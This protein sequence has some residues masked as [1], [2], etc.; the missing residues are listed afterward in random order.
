MGAS[1]EPAQSTHDDDRVACEHADR[2]G[3]CPVIGLPYTEQ[4]A[5][6]RG[7][8]VQSV[9]RYA[10]LELV[11]TDAVAPA[12]PRV[13]YRTRAKL[14][15]STGGR[16]GLFAKGGGHQVVDIPGC[17]VLASVLSRVAGT[18]RERIASDETCTGPLCP[19][20]PG[21]SGALRAVDLREVR[22]GETSR[23][24]VTFVVQRERVRDLASLRAAA[25]ALMAAL[26]EIAGV[27]VNFHEG[28]APQI[29][30][31][32]TL[33]LAGAS[34]APDRVGSSVHLAT[35]GSFVQAHRG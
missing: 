4:L 1:N 12:H 8:V 5:L 32:E 29:L 13:G 17:R 6:K 20:D 15:V 25:S 18:L 24:L 27:A 22:D 30:G 7:R 28:D 23:V 31:P 21:G 33:P 10:A 34:A 35:F 26:P 11:Y 19:Y 3:G 16:V 2:C 14:I 9:A